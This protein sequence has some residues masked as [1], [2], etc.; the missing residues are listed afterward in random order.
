MNASQ[1]TILPVTKPGLVMFAFVCLLV[2]VTR[3]NLLTLSVALAQR[4]KQ[5][6]SSLSCSNS[7]CVLGNACFSLQT[8]E[9][10]AF[11]PHCRGLASTLSQFEV[12]SR[13]DR[14]PKLR[15]DDW[16][17][18]IPVESRAVLMTRYVE[19]QCGHTFADEVWTTYRLALQYSTPQEI[20]ELGIGDLYIHRVKTLKCDDL[21]SAL[22]RKVRTWPNSSAAI[23]STK[24][25]YKYIHFGTK[26]LSYNDGNQQGARPYL[27]SK[28]FSEQMLQFQALF[29]SFAGVKRQNSTSP[30]MVTILQ[31]E[32][33]DHLVKFA[34]M[35][36]IVHWSKV[37]FPSHRIRITTW[38]AVSTV[39]QIRIMSQTSVLIG[40]SGSDILSAVFMKKGGNVIVFCRMF[41]HASQRRSN[42]V[43]L[44]LQYLN[45]LTVT[46]FC[47]D[48]VRF[49]NGTGDVAGG[50]F[51]NSVNASLF[52]SVKSGLHK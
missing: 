33:G 41:D 39:E 23:T 25:C 48:D 1:G 43:S 45:Y 2:L 29:Y 47:D 36:E 22:S 50:T 5:R 17:E 46:Q 52:Q 38:S 42:E 32:K 35:D 34:N 20:S 4:P 3:S 27:Q 51:Y 10:I 16:T 11:G 9:L 37:A 15:C 40:F 26:G 19:G 30:D 31:K 44:W 12:R 14:S 49:V 8:A 6:I 18:P 21:F 24:K 7:T 13:G 28:S